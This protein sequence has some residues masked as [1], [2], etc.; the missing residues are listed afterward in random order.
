MILK[1]AVSS[2]RRGEDELAQLSF[3]C[4]V[5]CDSVLVAHCEDFYVLAIDLSCCL[6]RSDYGGCGFCSDIANKVVVA[7]H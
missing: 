2:G 7:G 5:N 4:D 6:F 3:H 1:S